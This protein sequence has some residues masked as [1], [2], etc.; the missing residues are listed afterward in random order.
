MKKRLAILLVF[1]VTLVATDAVQ[2]LKIPRLATHYMQ[3]TAADPSLTFA[4]FLAEHYS[5]EP[6]TDHDEAED[7][8]LP[9]KTSEYTA[10]TVGFFFV[11]R[12]GVRMNA[13]VY[14]EKPVSRYRFSC[15]PS[16]SAQSIWQP[17]KNA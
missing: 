6:H 9:F 3:H 11:P 14:T 1:T 13:P 8:K 15:I 7:M 17:P 2:L 10:V 4:D 12:T 16:E 5:D